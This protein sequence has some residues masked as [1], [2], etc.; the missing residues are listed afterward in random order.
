M[1][2]KSRKRIIKFFCNFIPIPGIRRKVRTRLL[3]VKMV[4]PH[5]IKPVLM[6]LKTPLFL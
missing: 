1:K 2:V 5:K 4:F 6:I 3:K